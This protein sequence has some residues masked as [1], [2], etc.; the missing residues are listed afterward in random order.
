MSVIVLN[1]LKV[2]SVCGDALLDRSCII[3]LL[4]HFILGRVGTAVALRA[5]VFGFTVIFYDPYLADG[6][7]KSLG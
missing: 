7:E 3:Y 6:I 4:T 5:R 1:V 2:L